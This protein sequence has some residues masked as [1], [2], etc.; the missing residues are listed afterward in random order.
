MRIARAISIT[1]STRPGQASQ[2]PWEPG[3]VSLRIATVVASAVFTA[4]AL[5]PRGWRSI[6]RGRRPTRFASK[7]EGCMV[8][9]APV[10]ALQPRH[11]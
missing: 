9:G 2:L 11:R 4:A 7:Q 6:P 8:G 3:L 10:A 1:S 5:F